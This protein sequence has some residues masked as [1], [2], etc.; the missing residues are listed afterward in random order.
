MK[1]YGKLSIWLLD[2]SK[3]R[4]TNTW[5]RTSPSPTRKHDDGTPIARPMIIA[6]CW[7][8]AMKTRSGDV[9]ALADAVDSDE[10]GQLLPYAL[11]LSVIVDRWQTP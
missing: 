9:E 10:V 3:A 8:S 11:E 5:P 6:G 4:S 7:L 1:L 2:V